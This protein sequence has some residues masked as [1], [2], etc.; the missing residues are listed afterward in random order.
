MLLRTDEAPSHC[1]AP[2]CSLLNCEA[3]NPQLKAFFVSQSIE[4][5]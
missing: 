5:R 1:N 4:M 3:I 2:V